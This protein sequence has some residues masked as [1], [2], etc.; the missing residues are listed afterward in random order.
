V[1]LFGSALRESMGPKRQKRS[2]HIK[3]YRE[4]LPDGLSVKL[5]TPRLPFEQRAA[6]A[7]TKDDPTRGDIISAL[8]NL[9]Y[10]VKDSAAAATRAN[11]EGFEERFKNALG[12]L[13]AE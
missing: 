1:F 10:S 11:G 5:A 13:R 4:T 9:G 7:T 8:K 2:R 3:Y 6:A 12:L